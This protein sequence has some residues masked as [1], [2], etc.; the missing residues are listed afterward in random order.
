MFD[1]PEN[2]NAY[3][4]DN[5]LLLVKEAIENLGSVKRTKIDDEVVL[6]VTMDNGQQ[7]IVVTR[8]VTFFLGRDY[9]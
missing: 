4:N 3:N 7:F 9:D 5:F 2:Y 6:V 1:L 8:E